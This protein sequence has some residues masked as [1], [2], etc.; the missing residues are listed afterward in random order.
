MLEIG[1]I[2]PDFTLTDK[3]GNVRIEHTPALG[4]NVVILSSPNLKKGETY[5]LTVGS[6]SG[7]FEAS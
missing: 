3:D 4:Y 6:Q 7:E 2:A 1:M 5:N